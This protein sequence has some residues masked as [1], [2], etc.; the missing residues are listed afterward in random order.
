MW[1]IMLKILK[2][3]DVYDVFRARKSLPSTYMV[4]VWVEIVLGQNIISEIGRITR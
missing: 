4:M 3:S 1:L 2:A